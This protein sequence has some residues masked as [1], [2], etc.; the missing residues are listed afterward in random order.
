MLVA[1]AGLHELALAIQA[2]WAAAGR[3]VCVQ[4][5]PQSVVTQTLVVVVAE[6]IATRPQLLPALVAAESS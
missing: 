2:V 5:L 4:Y 1:V 3:D 6:P